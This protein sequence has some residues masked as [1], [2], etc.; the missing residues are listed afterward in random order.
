[1][2]GL[3][4]TDLNFTGRSF[5]RGESRCQSDA[6]WQR[7]QQAQIRKAMHRFKGIASDA[8][9]DYTQNPSPL[10]P[11]SMLFNQIM[12]PLTDGECVAHYSVTAPES[13][14]V[15]YQYCSDLCRDIIPT[16]SVVLDVG[17]N[18]SAVL[19]SLEP[20]LSKVIDRE[21]CQQL[22]VLGRTVSKNIVR[23]CPVD[24]KTTTIEP[25]WSSVSALHKIYRDARHVLFIDSM[26]VMDAAFTHC[27]CT[28]IASEKFRSTP[29]FEL[30][31]HSLHQAPHCKVLDQYG[32]AIESSEE[33]RR[34]PFLIAEN[35]L[36]D[37]SRTLSF[38]TRKSVHEEGLENAENKEFDWLIPFK[39]ADTTRVIIHKARSSG[40]WLLKFGDYR[41][42]WKRKA[43]KLKEDPRTF[44]S[45]SQ[46]SVLKLV[47][48]LWPKCRKAH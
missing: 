14:D 19:L 18:D 11:G 3:N 16:G 34:Y 32:H 44:L 31:L 37:F 35:R 29:G 7:D 39:G 2:R 40:Q 36:S 8:S 20:A 38:A 12:V 1:M 13:I 27:S 24:I 6:C 33:N 45:D 43:V 5:L 9:L 30:L 26:R 17:D 25:D 23:H 46:F 41:T 28:L 15:V 42:R 22:I 47:A 48:R 10:F 21:R 4:F